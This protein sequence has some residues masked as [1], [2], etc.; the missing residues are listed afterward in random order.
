M[1]CAWSA[2]SH[3]LNQCWDIVNWTL[4]N[5]S[6]WNLNRNLYIFIQEMHLK[7]SSGEWRPS[8]PGFNV[9]RPHSFDSYWHPIDLGSSYGVSF[10]RTHNTQRNLSSQNSIILYLCDMKIC[11]VNAHNVW[12]SRYQC[13]SWDRRLIM[14]MISPPTYTVTEYQ[15]YTRSIISIRLVTTTMSNICTSK[16]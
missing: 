6:Q 16:V 15:H 8:C 1:A 13:V 2:P 5:K 7:M 10:L 12:T 4:R 3:Y 11:L 9:L 14:S